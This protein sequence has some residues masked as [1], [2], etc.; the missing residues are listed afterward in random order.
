MRLKFFA[1]CPRGLEEPL[2]EELAE[3]G[4]AP[5]QATGGGVA[6]EGDWSACFAANRNSRIASRILWQIAHGPAR[7]EHDVYALASTVDWPAHF[8]VARTIRVATTSLGDTVRSIEFVTLKVKDAVCDVFRDACGVRPSVDTQRPDI[9]IQCLLTESTCTLYLDCSGEAL[10]KRG[11]RHAGE[12]P[13]REN[14]AAGILRLAGWKPGTPLFDPMCGSGTFLIEAA[15]WAAGIAPSTQHPMATRF[16]LQA[17]PEP[18]VFPG[19]AVPT[20]IAGSDVD[21]KLVREAS[22]N[23]QRA[24]LPDDAIE[25]ETIDARDCDPP[26][27]LAPGQ[28]GIVVM[29]PPYEERIE[30][31]RSSSADAFYEFF[32]ANM[33]RKFKGWTLYILSADMKLQ[34]KVRLAPERRTVLYNGALECR[35]YKFTLR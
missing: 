26:C 16:L 5:A 3:L 20:V 8:E 12:A 30:F 10:F 11:W 13:L 9:R 29:N 32:A 14:L 17:P 21:R 6:F 35:L 28:E 22:F 18:E 25:W 34:Q 27:E 31:M 4:I 7:S 24:G 15:Q 23:A 2:V 19:A 1:P 33:K